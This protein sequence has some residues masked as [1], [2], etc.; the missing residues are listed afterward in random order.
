MK[1]KT[2]L[3]NKHT[4]CPKCGALRERYLIY[5]DFSMDYYIKDYCT[6]CK[7][8]EVAIDKK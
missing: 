1:T 7:T 3:P 5:N 2:H 8:Y 6:K 4:K